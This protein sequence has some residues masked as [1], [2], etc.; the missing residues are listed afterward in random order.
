M[1][2]ILQSL[3]SRNF[4]STWLPTALFAALFAFSGVSSAG[5][6]IPP[7][8]PATK[9]CPDGVRILASQTCRPI[10]GI[11]Q[12][13]IT[14]TTLSS[15]M[16]NIWNDV[17]NVIHGALGGHGAGIAAAGVS[18]SALS[19]QTGQ[20]AAAGGG[21]WNAWAALAQVNAGYSFQPLQS[22]GYSNLTLGGIDYT[23]GNSLVVGAALSD[24][25]TRIDTSY[26]GGKISGNGNA[27]V[28]YLGWRIN[29]AWLLDATLGY[30]TTNLT[31]TD[32]SI[33]G[34]I[35]GSN[36]AKRSLGTLGLAY[37]QGIGKW[38]L[39]G[40]G[41]LLTVENKYSGFTFSNGT[42]VDA[43]TTRTSQIRLGGQAAYNAGTVVPFAGLVYIHD[44]QRPDQGAI[45]GQNAANDRDAWQVRAGL[46]FR[47]GG[48]LY[49]GIVLSTEVGRSQVKNDQIL[50]N[51]GLRF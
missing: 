30:G 39:T 44:F 38:V 12:P 15:V 26:N 22:G 3:K 41:S 8:P 5:L 34:G 32:N 28:P 21:N 45:A 42:P 33:A 36:R 49:G 46:N 20:A 10:A 37:N 40:K 4:A 23:F 13:G 9:L 17:G 7:P 18:R 19:G 43:T 47:S 24:E 25:R 6:F 2:S 27:L 50:F 31:S 16:I 14:E 35:T 29:N 48:A 11:G 1:Q 51:L